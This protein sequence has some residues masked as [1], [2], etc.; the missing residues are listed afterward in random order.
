MLSSLFRSAPI[1]ENAAFRHDQQGE[2]PQMKGVLVLAFAICKYTDR[3]EPA[4][5]GRLRH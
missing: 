4:Q 2:C 5:H 1:P 3:R